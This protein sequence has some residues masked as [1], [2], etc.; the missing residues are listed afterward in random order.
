[1]R[2]VAVFSQFARWTVG[3]ALIAGLLAAADAV[4]ENGRARRAAE[5]GPAE[6]PKRGANKVIK[7]GAQLAASHGIEDEPA[8]A[9]EWEQRGTAYGR[10]V[11]HPR[12]ITEVRAAFAGT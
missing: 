11:P 9:D 6:A 5:A 4:Q 12:G 7:L 3:L 2:L 8:R 10:L 1:M